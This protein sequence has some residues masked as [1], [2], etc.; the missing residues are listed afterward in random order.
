IDPADALPARER[1]EVPGLRAGEVRVLAVGAGAAVRA[2]DPM[3]VAARADPTEL[4]VVDRELDVR[5][6]FSGEARVRVELPGEAVRRHVRGY[7]DRPAVVL[8]C[9]VLRPDVA[10]QRLAALA[11]VHVVAARDAAL[12]EVAPVTGGGGTAD[13]RCR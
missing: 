6:A 10:V 5:L 1:P 12:E 11:A 2:D 13:A 9:A 3:R 7:R 4:A 8:V